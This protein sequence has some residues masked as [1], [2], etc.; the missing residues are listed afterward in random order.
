MGKEFIESEDGY[1]LK[2]KENVI[3]C[4]DCRK[5]NLKCFCDLDSK[6]ENLKRVNEVIQ[7]GV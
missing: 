1:V 4:W 6:K 2:E 3:K 5:E 7:N